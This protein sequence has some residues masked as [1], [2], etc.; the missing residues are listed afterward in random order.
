MQEALAE[1]MTRCDL[2][3]ASSPQTRAAATSRL[4]RLVRD[5]RPILQNFLIH[6]TR[7]TRQRLLGTGAFKQSDIQEY[8]PGPEGG[9]AFLAARVARR[10]C[11][12]VILLLD[13]A[14]Q[15]SDSPENRA[16]KRV[17]I[18]LH[19]PLLTTATA[20]DR[21]LQYLD[22]D[23]LQEH[24]ARPAAPD[25]W[26]PY[27][28]FDPY[29]GEEE[30]PIPDRPLQDRT[31]ALISHDAKKLSM[32]EFARENADML[33]Q[34]ARILTTG[35]TG[36]LLKL[37]FLEGAHGALLKQ[38][39]SRDKKGA[40]KRAR[41]EERLEKV[42]KDIL[43]KE[44]F[45]IDLTKTGLSA[46][47]T[48]LRN[49]LELV[50]N[51]AFAEK[52]MP[53]P[54]G[55][56]GGDVLIAEQILRDRCH[57][58]VFFHD[59]LTAHP[60]SADIRLLEHT[61]QLAN[62][63][64]ECVSEE[65]AGSQW[66]A[67]L[68]AELARRRKRPP[69]LPFQL[70]QRWGLHDVVLVSR[71]DDENVQSV[72]LGKKL[73]YACA[74]YFHQKLFEVLESQGHAHVA[75]AWGGVCAQVLEGLKKMEEEGILEEFSVLQPKITWYPL[76]GIMAAE[77]LDQEANI[78]AERFQ[79]FYGGAFRTI[80][81]AGVT[82]NPD[83]VPESVAELIRRINSADIILTSAT[84]WS[85]GG[86]E[87][88]LDSTRLVP[89]PAPVGLISG[90]IA[91]DPAGN[92]IRGDYS[93]VG[94]DHESLRIAASENRVLLIC[95]GKERHGVLAAVLRGRLASVLIST[96][97]TAAQMLKTSKLPPD[98]GEAGASGGA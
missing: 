78:L 33:L 15:W 40:K 70:R 84:Q 5:H 76:V 11:F 1:K 63:F 51:P 74:G 27:N 68:K 10:E 18:H 56:E 73:A 79:R 30:G 58:I 16:L 39:Y 57:S 31:L 4:F 54:S 71:S 60:H 43:R 29:E 3:I 21:W 22:R 96:S 88:T 8:P 90:A 75:V 53:L 62:V 95:G 28:W 17:C 98:G 83:K 42:A 19:I 47:L 7:G 49:E 35:T 50:A 6:S 2:I 86:T 41:L 52:L 77:V 59:P 72:G 38:A 65:R 69:G 45:E 85:P 97:A 36:W 91:I 92:Q 9:I 25:E 87:T 13:P 37:L 93:V 20:A 32:I 61:S 34:H 80:S 66:I 26:Q 55:P 44:P 81:C 12:G 94:V 82:R 67:G 23:A 64:A 46:A 24:T 48:R 89:Q 14:D